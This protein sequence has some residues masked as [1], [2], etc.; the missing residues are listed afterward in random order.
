[1]NAIFYRDFGTR[2]ESGSDL[3]EEEAGWDLPLTQLANDLQPTSRYKIVTIIFLLTIHEIKK[4]DHYFYIL[5][6]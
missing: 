1:M 4:L 5:K 6:K 3:E 2:I